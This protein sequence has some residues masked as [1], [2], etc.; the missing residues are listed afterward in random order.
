MF[1]TQK[2]KNLIHVIL[3]KKKN[4]IHFAEI[5]RWPIQMKFWFGR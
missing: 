4:L 3:P 2:K 5:M 1:Y